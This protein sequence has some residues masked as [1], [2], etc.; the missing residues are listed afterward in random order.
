MLSRVARNSLR[1][2]TQNCSAFQYHRRYDS[3][4]A[5]NV[6]VR[7]HKIEIETV[8]KHDRVSEILNKVRAQDGLHEIPSHVEH[9]V[10]KVSS[11]GP[12][13]SNQSG[14]PRKEEMM[15][16]DLSDKTQ[17]ILESSHPV[18]YFLER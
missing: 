12:G 11:R 14:E 10:T 17:I 6:Q 7:K 4:G 15:A 8:R 9:L 1:I 16:L 13:P 18:R 3:S 5:G 2:R